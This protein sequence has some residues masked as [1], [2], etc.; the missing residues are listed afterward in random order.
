MLTK[1]KIR[2]KPNNNKTYNANIGS[3]L[4]GFLMEKIDTEFSEEI[5]NMQLNPYSQYII[6]N[7]EELIWVINT[8][9]EKS[10]VE[11]ID[12][13][14]CI[15]SVVLKHRKEIL[16]VENISIDSKSYDELIEGYYM[17]NNSPC[18]AFKFLTPASFKH[19]GRYMIYPTPRLI[20]QSLMMQYNCFSKD[21]GI[22]LNDFLPLLE[23]MVKLNNYHL[24]STN[25]SLEG[26]KIPAFYGELIYMINAPKQII[27]LVH[28]LSEFGEYS[29]VGIKTSIGMGAIRVRH[30]I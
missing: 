24:Q 28:M 3:I 6:K 2:L 11:I 26:V 16:K 4:Q 21:I 17:A 15:E 20:F 22:T 1:L 27:N 30:N 8:L 9:D 14:S 10:R 23:D 19:S 29:G 5:H 25:F 7:G 12:K 13:L 18:I